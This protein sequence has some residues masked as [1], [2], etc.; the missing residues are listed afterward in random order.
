MQSNIFDSYD[1]IS[2]I[3]LLSSFKL[4]SDMN[5]IYEEAVIQL[6]HFFMKKRG[7]ALLNS[8]MDVCARLLQEHQ[9]GALKKYSEVV[10]YL[11]G[12]YATRDVF[13]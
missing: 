9:E 6:L 11:L 7:T 1:P 12:A 3:S 2:I 5:N 4:P 10:K 8:R 13:S